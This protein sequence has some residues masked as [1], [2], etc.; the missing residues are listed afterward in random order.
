MPNTYHFTLQWSGDTADKIQVGDAMKNIGRSKS[1]LVVAAVA[2]YVIVHPEALTPGYSFKASAELPLIRAQ[3]E[4]IIK[5]TVDA[6]LVSMAPISRNTINS[7]NPDPTT[8]SPV[9]VSKDEIDIMLRN[10]DLF[11]S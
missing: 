1:K 2:E 4:G 6:R 9:S 11:T 5:D 3:A 8:D 10:L 7:G